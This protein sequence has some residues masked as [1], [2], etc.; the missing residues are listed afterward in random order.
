MM[1]L[2][3]VVDDD[4]G[5]R[6]GFE[7][8][9]HVA[10]IHAM[11]AENGTNGLR[12]ARNSHPILMLVDLRLPDM[13]GVDLLRELREDGIDVPV[14]IM[15]AFGST[16]SAVQAMKRGASDYIEKPIG[17]DDLLTIVTRNA[18]RSQPT[19]LNPVRR[20]AWTARAFA[21]SVPNVRLQ[22]AAEIVE[23]R[24]YEPGLTLDLVARDVGVTAEHLCRL[25]RR[26][27]GEG[28]AGHVRRTRVAEARR[29]LRATTLSAKEIAFRVGFTS[30]SRLDRDF[31]RLCNVSPSAYRR[32]ASVPESKRSEP[33]D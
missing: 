33:Y 20:L 26:H 19:A 12:L 25:W 29:L 27:T 10:G 8:I 31:K 24:F 23:R 18:T 3:I 11:T 2:V 4:P 1:F 5:T 7:Q 6:E 16:T 22:K 13:S 14:V 21:E 30:P 17:V 15:T 32:A 9:L 28:F